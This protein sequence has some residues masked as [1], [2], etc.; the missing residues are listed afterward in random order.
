M[1]AAFWVTRLQVGVC[2]DRRLTRKSAMIPVPSMPAAF[3]S[4]LLSLTV[5]VRH[6]RCFR[7][8]PNLNLNEWCVIRL[9][10]HTMCVMRVYTHAKFSTVFLVVEK[11]RMLQLLAFDEYCRF[12]TSL[13]PPKSSRS[14]K[15]G[16]FIES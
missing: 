2:I 8:Y 4:K 10:V 15:S 3:D 1:P 14:I 12:D 11:S 13:Y 6:A 7:T 5:Q 9:C 16:L